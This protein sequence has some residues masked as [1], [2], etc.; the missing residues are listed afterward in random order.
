MNNGNNHQPISTETALSVAN[1]LVLTILPHT[2]SKVF[3]RMLY[4]LLQLKQFVMTVAENENEYLE[5][6]KALSATVDALY[7][8]VD[9]LPDDAT[10]QEIKTK[11]RELRP[12]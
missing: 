2:Q 11:L 4:Q 9:D 10:A 12:K 5:K 6:N 8:A 3:K 1:T 7:K